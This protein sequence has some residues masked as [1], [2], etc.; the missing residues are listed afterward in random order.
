[1]EGM[2]GATVRGQTDGSASAGAMSV[3]RHHLGGGTPP[4]PRC[5]PGCSLCPIVRVSF[6]PPPTPVS[7]SPNV[8]IVSM[9]MDTATEAVMATAMAQGWRFPR[10]TACRVARFRGRRTM[11]R[12]DEAASHG[13]DGASHGRSAEHGDAQDAWRGGREGRRSVRGHADGAGERG[14]DAGAAGRGAA[15]IGRDARAHSIRR[16]AMSGR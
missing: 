12:T 6:R 3:C 11:E 5:G 8:P 14:T 4:T 7:G 15:A 1:M 2:R 13:R 10:T 9:A 16:I